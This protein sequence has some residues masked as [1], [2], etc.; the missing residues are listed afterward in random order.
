M[1]LCIIAFC[2]VLKYVYNS[3]VSVWS[4][5]GVQEILTDK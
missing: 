4:R 5:V 3:V 1:L 2:I